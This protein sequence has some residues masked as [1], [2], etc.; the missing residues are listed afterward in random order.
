MA[1]PVP[2][3]TDKTLDDLE[4]KLEKKK[5]AP[6]PEVEHVETE[7]VE[8][9]SVKVISSSREPNRGYV[10]EDQHGRRYREVLPE[11]QRHPGEVPDQLRDDDG[12]EEELPRKRRRRREEDDQ[13]KAQRPLSHYVV[14]IVAAIV[15]SL[16]LGWAGCSMF[17][18]SALSTP[19]STEKKDWKF[20]VPSS[21]LQP[22]PTAKQPV[23]VPQ[24]EEGENP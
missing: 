9:E 24:N 6:K 21:V 2:D 1:D 11:G 8:K 17:T 18:R 20:S 7:D 4:K 10:I 15:F 5:R 13:P 3:V 16:A 19:E 14:G 23:A 22:E 12:E